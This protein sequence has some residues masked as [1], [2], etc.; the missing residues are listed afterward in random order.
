VAAATSSF[1]TKKPVLSMFH[2]LPFATS[3]CSTANSAARSMPL[4]RKAMASALSSG[5]VGACCACDRPGTS[6]A[7]STK[8][9]GAFNG[10]ALMKST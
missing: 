8:A 10:L 4:L 5:M 9:A 3:A 2:A 1:S 7:K 6:R